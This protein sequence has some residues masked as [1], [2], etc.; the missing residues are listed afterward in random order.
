MFE[1]I[2]MPWLVRTLAF[3]YLPLAAYI[4]FLVVQALPPEPSA[5]EWFA[6]IWSLVGI[7][8]AIFLWVFFEVWA[9]RKALY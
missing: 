8:A 3:F 2:A 9:S 4:V 5:I 1:F 6:A 7:A